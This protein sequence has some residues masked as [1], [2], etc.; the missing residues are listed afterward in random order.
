MTSKVGLIMFYCT[1]VADFT[2]L[3]LPFLLYDCFHFYCTPI[4]D[5]TVFFDSGYISASAFAA[6]N[7]ASLKSCQKFSVVTVSV[8]VL[9][10]ITVS[11]NADLVNASVPD[12]QF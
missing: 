2:A 8:T 4:A 3:L 10:V 9:L 6:I 1:I 5:F 7:A 11:V 12:F